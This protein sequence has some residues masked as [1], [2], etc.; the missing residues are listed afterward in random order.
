[1]P[2]AE[3][4]QAAR[5]KN[6]D[7]QMAEIDARIRAAIAAAQSMGTQAASAL[8]GLHASTSTSGTSSNSVGYSYSND[9][10]AAPPSVT[11]I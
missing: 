4:D 2:P 10:L 5:M 7:L 9:T 8:N 3:Y 6:G 1:M 11:S